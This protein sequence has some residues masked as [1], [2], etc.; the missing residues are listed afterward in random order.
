[1]RH[2]Q[3]P[4][5]RNCLRWVM[6]AGSAA[7]SGSAELSAL[8]HDDFINTARDRRHFRPRMATQRM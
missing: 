7:V 4:P 3:L 8:E 6:L 1:M 2:D 5:T